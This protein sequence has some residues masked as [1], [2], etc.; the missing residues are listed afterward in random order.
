VGTQIQQSKSKKRN[1]DRFENYLRKNSKEEKTIES[2]TGDIRGF[3][4][5]LSM[6]GITFDGVLNRFAVN[7]YKNRLLQE[8]YEP[9][10]INKKLNR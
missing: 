2:Y 7:S 3:I 1:N 4:G 5:F 10:T 8:N 9:T 6:K